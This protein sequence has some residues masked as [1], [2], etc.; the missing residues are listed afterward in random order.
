[1]TPCSMP[2]LHR[3]LPGFGCLLQLTAGRPCRVPP[4]PSVHKASVAALYLHLQGPS[5]AG[6]GRGDRAQRGRGRG[7]PGRGKG[8]HGRGRGQHGRGRGQR[9][10]GMGQRARGGLSAGGHE[11]AQPQQLQVGDDTQASL[12]MLVLSAGYHLGF[13][14]PW[15]RSATSGALLLSCSRLMS[16]ASVLSL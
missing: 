10:R 4:C 6:P 11:A 16:A 12:L 13:M 7:Q 1:M 14:R 2:A 8:Q 5:A 9:G 15:L 3:K